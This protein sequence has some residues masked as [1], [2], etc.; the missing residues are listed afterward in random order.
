[1]SNYWQEFLDLVLPVVCAGC[2]RPRSALCESCQA[3]LSGASVRRVRPRPPPP[4]LPPV[5]AAAAYV[6]EVRA[7]LLAHKERGAL[8]LAGPLGVALAGAV[9]RAVSGRSAG[10]V[11]LVPVP[12]SRRAVAGRGH[13]HVVRIVRAATRLLR[14]EGTAVRAVPALQQRRKVSD[15]AGLSAGE[16]WANLVGALEVPLGGRRKLAARPVVLVDDLV[17]T[18]ASLAEAARVVRR[19]GGEVLGAAVVAASLTDDRLH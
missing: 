1:M 11:S 14:R 16:R 3:R 8:R 5:F 15:Q 18:G 9:R 13:D 17:T 2:G 7:V 4:A 6:D 10:P 12:S 19:A